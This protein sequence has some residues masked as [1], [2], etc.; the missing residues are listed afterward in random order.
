MVILTQAYAGF[1]SFA[2]LLEMSLAFVDERPA[3][4]YVWRDISSTMDRVSLLVS[5]RDQ[6]E[7]E[8]QHLARFVK[9]LLEP[10]MT[11]LGYTPQQDGCALLYSY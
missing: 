1:E 9:K 6:F 3:S 8:E 5:E 2:D 4:Q 7:L 10:L 11:K